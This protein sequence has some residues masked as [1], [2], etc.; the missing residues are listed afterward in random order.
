MP[1]RGGKDLRMKFKQQWQG[2]NCNKNAEEWFPASVPGNIQYD[3]GV[4][5]NFED[6]QYADNY[7][8]YLPLEDDHWEYRTRLSYEK[9]DGERVFFVS[10]GIDYRYDVLL[11][12]ETVYSY[13]GMFRPFEIDL[14]DRLTGDD[15]LTVHIYP[16]PKTTTGRVGTRDE[17][18]ASCKPPVMYGWDW[19]PRLLISGLWHDAYIE[20]RGESYIGACEVLADLSDDLKTGTVTY[21]FTCAEDCETALYD[22]DGNEV[23]RGTDR[24]VTVDSP[25]LWW[26]NGQGTAYLYRWEITNGSETRTGHIGFRTI[27][28]V[29]NKGAEGPK[30]FPKGRY[31]A[32]ITIELNGRRIFAKGS[33]W[34][35]PDI[36]WGRIT[37]DYYEELIALARDANMNIFRMW[38]G[39]GIAKPE[40]YDLC[41]R[42]GI[43][44]WQEFV[45][46]CNNYRGTKEYL[47]VLENEATSM[48]LQLRSHPS[49]AFW[50][51]GNELFNNWSG[52][53]DQSHALR[54]LNK[55]C[56]ELDFKRAFLYTSPIFGM[57]HGGYTFYD[58]SQGGEVFYQFQHANN[59]AYTEFGVPSISAYEDLEK[60]IPKEELCIP[61][62][63]TASWIAHHGF[64]AWGRHRWLCQDVLSMYFGEPETVEDLVKQSEWLQCEGY[65][66]AFEEMRRQWPHCSMGIN[67]CYNEPWITVGN[68]N[69]LTYPAKPK[70]AYAYVK[71][72]MRPTLFSARIPKFYWRAG[73]L[74]EAELWLL[75]DLPEAVTGT[76]H[77]SVTV[78]DTTVDLLDWNAS[79]GANANTQGPTVRCILP[80]APEGTDRFTLTLSAEDGRESAYT[81]MY[82]KKKKKIS[83]REMNRG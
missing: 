11:N 31:E 7:K 27:R 80:D 64:D 40:F 83:S 10:G 14:T 47:T 5:H 18:D 22:M 59:T 34:V 68:N 38:G 15:T 65:S 62:P 24:T 82:G 71:K 12:G 43:L 3:Y 4:F 78:G 63:R 25:H 66:G 16:H 54:L 79:A 35:N 8:Q 56:Y 72:S 29:R 30:M 53:T 2:R 45:L 1:H 42:Y 9:R 49:L 69:L 48:I 23:Y 73:E 32:P 17:S 33:N 21:A 74:F 58:E 20:T 44:L 46:A 76:V 6:V 28:L 37:A 26:C 75:N 19:N 39:A 36:F 61:I 55:L 51:G 70:P 67:W 81:Y 50:C 52:M 13:E 57:A 41:D 77:A 60:I